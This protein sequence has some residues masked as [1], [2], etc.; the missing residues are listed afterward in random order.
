MVRSALTRRTATAIV[1]AIAAST[2]AQAPKSSLTIAEAT[3]KAAQLGANTVSVHGHFWCGKEG[4][5]I[6]DS[7]YKS[8]LRIS[9]SE[10]YLHKHSSFRSRCGFDIEHK[11]NLVT[12]T[13]HLEAQQD[14]K[15]ALVTDEL[16][17]DN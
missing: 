5:M 1:C 12:M 2:G 13:G 11:S 15:L 17:F 10:A 6:Y 4:S 7:Y 9:F 14:G 16:T 3:K 8:I